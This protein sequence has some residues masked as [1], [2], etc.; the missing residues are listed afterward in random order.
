MGGGKKKKENLNFSQVIPLENMSLDSHPNEMSFRPSRR[1]TGCS[2]TSQTQLMAHDMR[3]DKL[4]MS[5]QKQ[6]GCK[7]A[8]KDIDQQLPFTFWIVV[9]SKVM[10]L[11]LISVH[12]SCVCGLSKDKW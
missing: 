12:S 4:T 11:F 3:Q 7:V 1:N 10:V 8:R 2:S 6:N 5:A 9:H